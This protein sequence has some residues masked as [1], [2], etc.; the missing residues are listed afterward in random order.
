MKSSKITIIKSV[1]TRI[2]EVSIKDCVYVDDKVYLMYEGDLSLEE[3]GKELKLLKKR[4]EKAN[5]A[6]QHIINN[7]KGI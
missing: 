2:T 4:L 3:Y 1:R 5:R 7:M 6:K